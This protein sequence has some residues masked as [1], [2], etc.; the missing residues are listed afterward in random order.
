L[1]PESLS[2]PFGAPAGSL[3]ALEWKRLGLFLAWGGAA[4][5]LAVVGASFVPLGW[6]DALR[7]SAHPSFFVPL[8]TA[9]TILLLR[10]DACDLP[11]AE[12]FDPWPV[13]RSSALWLV[14]GA[15]LLAATIP[16]FVLAFGL[17]WS[18]NGSFR[19][20]SSAL[21]VWAIFLTAAAEEIAFRGY[22]F[23]RLLRLIGFWPAQ[24]LVAGLFAVSHLT[25]GGYALAPA[26]VGTVAGSLLFGAAF[27]RTR[28]LAAPIALH[29]GWNL[30][31]HLLLNPLDPRATPLRVSFPHSPSPGE[32]A[33]ILAWLGFVMVAGMVAVLRFQGR[34]G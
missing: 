24:A 13:A 14:A 25:L 19:G 33:L 22:A 7:R 10:R 20:T 17:R 27:V 28:S 34:E 16:L 26:L 6:P 3:R 1:K 32:Y 2:R 8:G 23:W 18:A 12:R 11:A 4:F 9:I 21:N 29:T 15:A 30:A 31:Q 5:L